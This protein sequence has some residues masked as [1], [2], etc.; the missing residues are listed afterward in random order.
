M[1]SDTLSIL[2]L[3]WMALRLDRLPTEEPAFHA[4]L[5]TLIATNGISLAIDTWDA[6]RFL[7]GENRPHYRW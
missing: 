2:M 3:A 7:R 6:L 1:V 5:V 4:W